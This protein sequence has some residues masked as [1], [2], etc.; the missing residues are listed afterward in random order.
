MPAAAYANAIHS[1]ATGLTPTTL[2]SIEQTFIELQSIPSTASTTHNPMTQS[3]F[4]PPIVNS[5]ASAPESY[6]SSDSSSE[7][8]YY[9]GPKRLRIGDKTTTI[10]SQSE[11]E[12]P[13]RKTH[14]RQL[15]DDD[16][17]VRFDFFFR[18]GVGAEVYSISS[19]TRW[20]RAQRV[21]CMPMLSIYNQVN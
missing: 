8:D 4:V 16:V 18:I 5:I 13:A 19:L 3:G 11:I 17:R 6:Y 9:P 15:R 12:N 1:G 7:S 20:L 21:K 10:M 2:S 14:R